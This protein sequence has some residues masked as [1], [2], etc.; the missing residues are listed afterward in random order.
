MAA[1][2]PDIQYITQFYTYGS[3]AKVLELKPAR[4]KAKTILPKAIPEAKI[5]IMVDPAAIFGIVVAAVMLVLM[6][7]GVVQYL[8]VCE[9]YRVMNDY[10]IDLQNENVQL[11]QTY[12]AGFDPADIETKAL[13][14]GMIPREQAEVVTIHVE[15]PTPEPEPTL[16]ENICWYFNELFA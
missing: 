10:V 7:V 16:W 1:R 6:V 15:I 3:E 11:Q 4:K 13:A 5:R 14:I 8:N 2:K 12:E 9:E